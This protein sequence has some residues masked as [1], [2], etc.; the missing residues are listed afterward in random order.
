MPTDRETA[1]RIVCAFSW[2]GVALMGVA[3]NLADEIERALAAKG[4]ATEREMVERCAQVTEGYVKQEYQ[5]SSYSDLNAQSYYACHTIAR[6]IRQLSPP[7]P[8]PTKE[9]S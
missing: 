2:H 6:A 3:Q 5:F 9:P 8:A 4:I 7:D 1:E